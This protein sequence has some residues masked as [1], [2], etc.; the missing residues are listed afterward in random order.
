MTKKLYKFEIF[1]IDYTGNNT[2]KIYF[3]DWKRIRNLRNVTFIENN[4]ILEIV[5]IEN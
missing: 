2:Y 4:Q 3:L 5:F 1:L